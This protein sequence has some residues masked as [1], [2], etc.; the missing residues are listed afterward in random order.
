[1]LRVMRL[2]HVLV[3]RTATVRMARAIQVPRT[4]HHGVLAAIE[5]T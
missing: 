1:M 3:S 5:F 2:D 4:D